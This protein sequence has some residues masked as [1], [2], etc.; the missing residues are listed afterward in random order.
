M[1][2]GAAKTAAARLSQETLVTDDL[3]QNGQG[4]ARDGG[5][6][7]FVTGALPGERVRVA[8]DAMHPSYASA[9][10]VEVIDAS[11]DR[12]ASVCPVFPRCG[13]C[14]TLHLRYGAQLEWK[15]RMVVDALERIGKLQGASV[16][17]TVA[18]E[19]LDHTRYRNKVS[20]VAE[21]RRGNA[22][23]GFYEARSHRIVPIERCP[24]LL[25]RLDE[26]VRALHGALARNSSLADGVRHVVIRTGVADET[27]VL[28]FATQR[29]RP[30]L[31]AAVGLLRE[32]I[33]KLT[34]IVASW[35]PKNENAVLGRRFATLW[36]SPQTKE[37]VLDATFRFGVASFFQINTGILERIATRVLERIA[38]ANRIVDLYSGV[39]TFAVLAAMRGVVAT[40][41]ES[42]AEAVDEAAVNAARNGVTQ[43]AFERATAL[44]AVQGARGQTLL[45]DAGAVILDPPRRGCEPELLSALATS[46]VPKIL[47]LS[48]NPATLARDARLLVDGG[49]VLRSVEPYDMFPFT[50]HVEVLVEFDR[51]EPAA[52]P[53]NR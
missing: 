50:G 32:A 34:G 16:A 9:Q 35:D 2:S 18:S 41:V 14:Q 46:G 13:G 22:A 28:A 7:V 6:V 43:A 52:I 3:L 31:E 19:F 30:E 26:A 53:A 51:G 47:Y 38:G 45:A 17:P 10:A 39:G 36:G 24:V 40:G 33:P 5:L 49:F 20:L 25:P 29:R 27:L 23:I 11:P 12:V 42:Q 37:R 48:C 1:S 8:V 21:Q 44:E 15:R 4:V